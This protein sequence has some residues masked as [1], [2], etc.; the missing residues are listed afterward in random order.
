[1]KQLNELLQIIW[2]LDTYGLKKIII[3]Y[4]KDERSNLNSVINALKSILNYNALGPE[5]SYYGTC[6]EHALWEIV[7]VK[8]TL[9]C[10]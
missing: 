6:F 10:T 8:T 3:T 4:V 9:P 2:I 7:F 1:M 5:E